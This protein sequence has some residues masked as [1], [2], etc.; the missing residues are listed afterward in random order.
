MQPIAIFADQPRLYILMT[1]LS[2][3]IVTWNV[4]PLLHACLQSIAAATVADPGEPHQRRFGPTA[5]RTLEVI[6]VDNAGHDETAAQL[7]PNFPWV[8]FL[9]SATNLGFTGGNNWG[10]RASQGHTIFFL[11]PDT[12]IL[13]ATTGAEPLSVQRDTLWQL[14]QTLMGDDQLGMVGPQLRY[15]DGTWQNNRRRLPTPLTGFWESTWLGRLWPHNPWARAYHMQDQAAATAHDVDWLMGSAMFARRAAL[16]A[17]QTAG[18]PGPFDEA[19]FMYSEELDLC[20]RLRLAGWRIVYD[21]AALVMHYEGRSSEQVVAARHIRFNTSKVHYYEKYF[22]RRW[23]WL[24]RQ[25][26]L[27]EYRLQWLIEWLKLKL[28][29]KAPLRKER[30]AV[31]QQVLQSRFLS[32]T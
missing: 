3:I 11:N 32:V 31:Y 12:E 19:F 25:Y 8:R 4:W 5:E 26:L 7:P 23:A 29:H 24:L 6:V 22:G 18:D 21:P 30:I 15:G 14:Y 9:H 10:Y 1:D 28:G 13:T 27:S 16:E 17:I 20:H 2:I